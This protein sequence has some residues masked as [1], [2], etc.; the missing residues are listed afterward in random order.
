[1]KIINFLFSGK[2]MGILMVIFAIS[3]G[4]ATFI[5]NDF[6]AKTA[7]LLIYNAWWFEMIMGLMVV[8]FAGTIYTKRLYRKSKLNILAMH[9]ALIIII[10]GAGITRYF[11]FEGQ[12]HIRNGQTSNEIVTYDDYVNILV[13]D[14]QSR[15]HIYDKIVLS[16]INKNVYNTKYYY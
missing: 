11:G 1:M 3:I 12:M 8:N 10:I 13:D 4:Y 14:Q 9:L 2:L 16:P 5:E 15:E 6:D 7:K